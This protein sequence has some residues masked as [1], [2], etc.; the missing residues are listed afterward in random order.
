MFTAP[1]RLSDIRFLLFQICRKVQCSS[2]GISQKVCEIPDTLR[3]TQD[4]LLWPGSRMFFCDL[5]G[6]Q[7]EAAQCGCWRD[8]CPVSRAARQ[9]HHRFISVQAFVPALSKQTWYPVKLSEELLRLCSYW[10]SAA[11]TPETAAPS[12]AVFLSMNYLTLLFRCSGSLT[13]FTLAALVWN[14]TPR[15][16][17]YRLLFRW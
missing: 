5:F 9:H 11:A 10:R 13:Y 2:D 6:G 17:E 16:P 4:S 14:Y 8:S 1:D 7:Q 12:V 15:T 3:L